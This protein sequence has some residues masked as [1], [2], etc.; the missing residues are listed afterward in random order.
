MDAQLAALSEQIGGLLNPDVG[1]VADGVAHRVDR[2]K[3][4]GNGQVPRCAQP[5][6]GEC[7]LVA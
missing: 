1:R 6:P 4:L 5:Q 3:E 7:S 2:L